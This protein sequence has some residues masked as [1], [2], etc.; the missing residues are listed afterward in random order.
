MRIAKRVRDPYHDR[1]H[2]GHRQQGFHLGKRHQVLALQQL[3]RDETQVVLLARVVDRDDVR[4]IEAAGG[5]GFAE[6]TRLRVLEFV[7]LELLGQGHRLDR[8]H[9][10]D[11][12]VA[13]EIDH[14]HRALAKL[15]FDLVAAQHGLLARARTVKDAGIGTPR[16]TAQDHRFGQVLGA[17]D[18]L[19]EILVFRVIGGH[20]L[21][22]RLRLV[23]LSLAFKIQREVVHVVHHRVVERHLAELVER[24]VQLTLPLER[25][26]QHAVGLG[27]FHIRLLLAGLGNDIPLGC[28]QQM[29]DE[30]QC[31]RHHQLDPHGG[32]HHQYEVRDHQHHQNAQRDHGRRPCLEP[33]QQ[34]DQVGSHQDENQKLQVRRP[35]RHHEEVLGQYRRHRVRHLFHGRHRRRHRRRETGTDPCRRR[36]D[37]HDLVGIL[38]R[39]NLACQHIVKRIDLKRLLAVPIL[40][41][42]RVHL[43]QLIG[44]DC[45]LAKL[46]LFAPRNLDVTDAKIQAF[47][48][49]HQRIRGK[50]PIEILH[51]QRFCT[52]SAID[53]GKV[54]EMAETGSGL[55]QHFNRQLDCG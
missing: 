13:P 40:V 8:H 31:G 19:P 10:A 7:G 36:A 43:V 35:A 1:H 9:T 23:E 18:L 11:L 34:S 4:M 54:V 17:H 5:F 55:A 29:P 26:A 28:Q 53:V 15:L 50:I 47:R 48:C 45:E 44:R 49:D 32:R 25:Q 22:H 38:R 52:N 27:R 37:Q 24:H 14:A 42:I 3:H 20:V 30:Q 21:I 12:G 41:V 16:R 2:A 51:D 33:R 6:K 46:Q 39:R